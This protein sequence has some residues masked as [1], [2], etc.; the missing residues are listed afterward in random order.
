VET[1]MGMP[2]TYN[3][4]QFD[5]ASAD[6]SDTL[7]L[8]GVPGDARNEIE[9]LSAAGPISA[10][11][12]A[13]ASTDHP[14]FGVALQG[15]RVDLSSGNDGKQTLTLAMQSFNTTS[16][17]HAVRQLTHLYPDA[18]FHL[19]QVMEGDTVGFT[20]GVRNDQVEYSL[21]Y[22]VGQQPGSEF[23]GGGTAPA[24]VHDATGARSGRSATE[25]AQ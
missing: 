21:S 5:V 18:L 10:T 8:A 13:T 20:I 7:R 1:N 25:S 16:A 24:P 19:K 6:L 9:S 14:L 2:I 15:A 17:H 22:P 23:A 11:F 3:T 12:Q 4:I